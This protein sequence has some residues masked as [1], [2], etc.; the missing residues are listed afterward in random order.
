[1][2][3]TLLVPLLEGNSTDSLGETLHVDT[4]PRFP[5]WASYFGYGFI[6]LLC[7]TFVLVVHAQVQPQ[8]VQSLTDV[9]SLLAS[10][11]AKA[12]VA[13]R[14]LLRKQ[15]RGARR[16]VLGLQVLLQQLPLQPGVGLPLLSQFP[17]RVAGLRFFPAGLLLCLVQLALQ[18]SDPLGHLGD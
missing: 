5:G 1:M 2:C 13:L 8:V 12:R 3:F 17:L 18:R 4:R 14:L 9:Q 15:P 16:P 10:V 6:R 7:L 11:G